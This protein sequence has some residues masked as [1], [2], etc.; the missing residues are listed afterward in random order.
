MIKL[1]SHPLRYRTVP[2]MLGLG[3]GKKLLDTLLRFI[4]VLRPVSN[5]LHVLDAFLDFA[6]S[7]PRC[8]QRP[9]YYNFHGSAGRMPRKRPKLVKVAEQLRNARRIVAEQM[10]V[11]ATA[12]ANGEPTLE[13][14]GTL[15]TYLSGL[16]HFEAH[17]RKMREEAKAKKGESRAR[18]EQRRRPA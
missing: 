7:I 11:V 6:H 3:S 16:A 1:I 2:A 9:G 12:R 13:A 14:E 15:R 18:R 5:P 10:A 4:E 8:V 17:E